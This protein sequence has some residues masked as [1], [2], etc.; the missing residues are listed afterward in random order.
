MTPRPAAAPQGK[1]AAFLTGVDCPAA[2][3]CSAVGW[4][5]RGAAGAARALAATWNGAQ[6][7]ARPVPSIG[8]DSALASV[9]CAS[10]AFCLAAGAVT[11][12]WNGVRWRIAQ[13]SVSGGVSSV[14]C[15]APGWCQAAGQSADDRR[16]M[17]ARWNGRSWLPES[18]PAPVPAPEAMT[19]GGVSCTSPRFCVAVGSAASG[20]GARP[21]PAFRQRPVAEEWDGS[22]W[23]LLRPP[24]AG[25]IS[26]LTAVSCR[27]PGSCLAVGSSGQGEWP[28]AERWDGAR[29]TVEAVP[30]LARV[31]YTALAAVSCSARASCVAVGAYNGAV[32]VAAQWDGRRWAIRRLPSPAGSGAGPVALAGVSCGSPTACLAVGNAGGHAVAELWNGARWRV[33]PLPGSW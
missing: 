7:A 30:P 18:V 6:W 11:E 15:P 33:T 3:S 28:L 27:S 13:P 14:S 1:Q 10:P 21:S 24:S 16:P 4:R 5:Y 31:G 2:R 23:R 25:R 26:E 19:L 9:S 32:G 17:A 8:H 22:R 12:A 20:V 29:W